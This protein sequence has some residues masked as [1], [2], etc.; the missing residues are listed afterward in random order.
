M[1]LNLKKLAM[2]ISIPM[3]VLSASMSLCV[4]GDEA[5]AQNQAESTTADDIRTIGVG[6]RWLAFRKENA[7]VGIDVARGPTDVAVYIQMGS[8]W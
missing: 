5:S 2:I 7:W 1:T 6:G 8:A 4:A 3:F